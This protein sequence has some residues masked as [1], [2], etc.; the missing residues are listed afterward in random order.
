MTGKEYSSASSLTRITDSFNGLFRITENTVLVGGADEPI[1]LPA[2]AARTHNE[3]RHT[4]DYVSS[5]LHE[6]AH[7]CIAG[8]DRRKLEDYGYWYAPDG[9]SDAQQI[10]FERVEVKPQAL[11]WLFSVACGV[12]FRLSADNTEL[13][14]V[15]SDRFRAAVFQQARQYCMHGVNERS[16]ALIRKYSEAFHTHEP[17]SIDHYH[18]A[19]LR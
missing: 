10:E 7:W 9:R 8:A 15:P 5:A 3:I 1:Y 14:A 12:R 13:G 11:E 19:A 16:R 17:L 2:G 4:R 6:I 18:M